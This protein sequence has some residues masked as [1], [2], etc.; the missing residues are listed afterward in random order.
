[1]VQPFYLQEVGEF[2]FILF[3][4]SHSQYKIFLLLLLLILLWT[5]IYLIFLIHQIL[6]KLCLKCF[7][8]TEVLWVDTLS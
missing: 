6:S 4:C 5:I 7:A 1:M 3:L 2:S 8:L